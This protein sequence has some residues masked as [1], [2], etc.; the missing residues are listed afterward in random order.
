MGG[1]ESDA[2]F[3]SPSSS[4]ENSVSEA[5]A[6]DFATSSWS[7]VVPLARTQ[8]ERRAGIRWVL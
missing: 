8:L 4:L 1:W 3:V 6:D 2:T 7:L 5:R